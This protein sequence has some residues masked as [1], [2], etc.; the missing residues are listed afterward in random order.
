MAWTFLRD[1]F[2]LD[3]IEAMVGDDG[4]IRGPAGDGACAFVTRAD[5]A[6]AATAVLTDPGPHA[7]RTYDLTGPEALTLDDAA[8]VLTA[9]RG[10]P[11]TYHDET[12][13]EAY[14]SRAPYGAPDWQVDAWV[15]TYTAIASG[16][17]AQVS[18]A[19]EH[20]TGRA[21]TGLEQFLRD[22]RA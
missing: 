6:R 8:S 4:V 19:V 9:V 3:F 2:Y 7:G 16:V 11:V 17:M 10:T 21:P 1:S 18:D 12:L 14:A 13:A 5:V 15:S 20:L 22:A